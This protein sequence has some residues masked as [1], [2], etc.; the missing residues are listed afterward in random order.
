MS[1]DELAHV[2]ENYVDI[3][4]KMEEMVRDAMSYDGCSSK[5]FAKL[6]QMVRDMRTP[7]YPGCKKKWNKVFTSLKLLQLKA[8][9]HWTDRGF[10]ALLDLLKDML[11]EDNEVPMTTYEAKQTICPMGLEVEKIHACKND[12]V[13]F[14]GDNADLNECP[15]CGT[16]RYKKRKDGGDEEIKHG[17][18]QKVA[19]YLSLIPR[20]RRLFASSKDAELLR[21]HME[22]RKIDDHI[23]H[24]ADSTQWHVLDFKYK[25]FAKDLRSLRL[26]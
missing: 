20:L 25:E 19:W 17:A 21:W 10:K 16:P 11:P 8:A 4:P 18:P 2:G 26:H 3:A 9:H 22:G 14:R 6:K 15:E 12:C 24:P 13:L 7:L 5:E 23:R 1:E